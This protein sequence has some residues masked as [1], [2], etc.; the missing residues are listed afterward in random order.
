MPDNLEKFRR[1]IALASSGGSHEATFGILEDLAKEDNQ[2]LTWIA[3]EFHSASDPIRKAD[4][5]RIA[6]VA[7]QRGDFEKFLRD[8][9][10]WEDSDFD[11]LEKC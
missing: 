5:A 11:G 1:L 6:V 8:F 4:L 10:H 7:G 3:K 9:E 2:V